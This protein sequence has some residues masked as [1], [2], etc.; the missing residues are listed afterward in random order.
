MYSIIP[1]VTQLL[2]LSMFYFNRT[3]VTS[4]R[5]KLRWFS[6]HSRDGEDPSRYTVALIPETTVEPLRQGLAAILS[7]N[8]VRTRLPKYLGFIDT[9]EKAKAALPSILANDVIGV[10]CEGVGLSRWGRLCVLQISA[11]DTVFVCDALRSGVIHSL[12]PVLEAN[13]IKKVLHDCREDSAALWEQFSIKLG[14]VYD[15]QA[16]HLVRKY[17]ARVARKSF[18]FAVGDL[19]SNSLVHNDLQRFTLRRRVVFWFNTLTT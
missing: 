11:G 1:S 9:A 4:L 7:D 13:H 17:T 8:R 19:R 2:H 16:A 18:Y 14:G 3:R 12:R 5:G 10:D 6:S 15:T